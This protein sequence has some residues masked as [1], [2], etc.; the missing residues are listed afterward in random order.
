MKIVVFMKNDFELICFDKND[1][2]VLFN[3]NFSHI[4]FELQW[5]FSW[6]YHLHNFWSLTF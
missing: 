2:Y 1:F 3:K 4:W 5:R 6:R